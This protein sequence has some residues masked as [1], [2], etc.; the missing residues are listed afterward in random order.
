M[1]YLINATPPA[2]VSWENSWDFP[3][4]PVGRHHLLAKNISQPA[5][6]VF[7][8]GFGYIGLI[9]I[10]LGWLWCGFGLA[11]L[12]WCWF[13]LGLG[14]VWFDCVGFGVVG[15]DWSGWVALMMV[16]FGFMFGL[17]ELVLVWLCLL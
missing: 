17:V 14:S 16:C 12:G 10:C 6:G 8:L 4:S 11:G 7:G 3:I 1:S 15:W 5:E 13:A 2:H 9:F